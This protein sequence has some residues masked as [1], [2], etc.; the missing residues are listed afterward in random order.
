MLKLLEGPPERSMSD[1]I[2]YYAV[3]L[4]GSWIAKISSL[5]QFEDLPSESFLAGEIKTWLISILWGEI[6]CYI[7]KTTKR[8]ANASKKAGSNNLP[9]FSKHFSFPNVQTGFYTDMRN[10]PSGLAG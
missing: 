9:S 6:G 4:Q 8:E 2:S 7:S 3:T 5:V 1:A 10:I